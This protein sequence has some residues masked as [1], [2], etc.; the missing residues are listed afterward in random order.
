MFG[1][2]EI[3]TVNQVSFDSCK[4]RQS[5]T[6]FSHLAVSFSLNKWPMRSALAE[7][8]QTNATPNKHMTL[9]NQSSLRVCIGEVFGCVLQNI[10]NDKNQTA[11]L[12]I[13]F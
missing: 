12:L 9:S 11:L 2:D 5:R 13:D 10:A 1:N 3:N 6:S 7:A 8:R 4:A